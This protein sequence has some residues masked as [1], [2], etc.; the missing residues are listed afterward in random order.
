MMLDEA[1]RQRRQ[2][3]TRLT[4]GD[5]EPAAVI[6]VL[7]DGSEEKR[8][9]AVHPLAQLIPLITPGDLDRLSDDIAANGVNE[10]LVMFGG[11]VLDGRNRLA[12]ASVTGIPVRLREF[13][14]D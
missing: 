2:E 3:I 8:E 6:V 14:G 4:S 9:L 11:R 1:A 12:V 10:P 7:G 13:D 5:Y